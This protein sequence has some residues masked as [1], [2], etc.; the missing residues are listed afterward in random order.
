MQ[1]INR[2]SRMLLLLAAVAIGCKHDTRDY[3]PSLAA[4]ANW[5]HQALKERNGIAWRDNHQP[6][7]N[8]TN[9]GCVLTYEP[10]QGDTI[11]VDL[12]D[13]NPKT[14]AIHKIGSNPW[15]VFDTRDFHRSVRYHT[16]T[17]GKGPPLDYGAPDGGFA[18]NSDDVAQS[19]SK[20][21]GRAVQLCGGTPS[22][23]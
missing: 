7:A 3:Q 1:V 13:V 2:N 14:I 15:V 8:L 21:L 6:F 16:A 4:T 11:K 19:F 17:E 22:T 18:L 9:D 10:W 23:F 20:A 5:M 12:S